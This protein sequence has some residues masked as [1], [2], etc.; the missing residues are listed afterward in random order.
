MKGQEFGKEEI[1]FKSN[2]EDR[3]PTKEND[4]NSKGSASSSRVSSRR[5]TPRADR[6]VR[7]REREERQREIDAVQ[8]LPDELCNDE[9][10]Y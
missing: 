1:Y 7:A 4:G 9:I 10:N 2:N 3:Q 6:L 5:A 8:S